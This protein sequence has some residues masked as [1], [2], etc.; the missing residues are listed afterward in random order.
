MVRCAHTPTK[1][2][3]ILGFAL[4]LGG[5]QRQVGVVVDRF[6]DGAPP[7][8]EMRITR[9][10]QDAAA[11]AVESLI[12]GKCFVSRIVNE[13]E[14][15]RRPRVSILRRTLS[16]RLS[17]I[18]STSFDVTSTRGSQSRSRPAQGRVFAQG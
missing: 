5:V 1:D 17:L 15:G 9:P 14:A 11:E 6:S 3:E 12:T 10:K 7:F 8:L 4:E 16:V 2:G 13:N 18:A